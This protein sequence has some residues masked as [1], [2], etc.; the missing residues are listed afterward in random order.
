MSSHLFVYGTLMSTHDNPWAKRLRREAKLVGKGIIVGR[1]KPA[2]LFF[3]LVPRGRGWVKG[4]LYR[5]RRADT[6]LRAL[7]VYEGARYRRMICQVR[8]RS[9]EVVDAWVYV[10]CAYAG[11]R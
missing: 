1:L 9:S 11:E 2:G 3:T 7:D 6:T 10:A 5:L 8:L 4:E